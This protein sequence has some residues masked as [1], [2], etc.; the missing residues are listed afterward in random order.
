MTQPL[1]KLLLVGGSASV[2][3]GAA[4]TISPASRDF[5]KVAVRGLREAEFQVTLSPGAA[6]GI[7][8][9][10]QI[11]GPDAAEFDVRTGATLDPF[12]QFDPCPV[13]AQGVVC[14]VKVA[15]TPRSL[16]PKTATLVVADGSSS[17]SAMLKGVGIAA[18]CTHTVVP[19]NYALHY[20]GF[21][22]WSDGGT[23]HVNVDVVEGVAS[24]NAANADPIISGP[25]LVAVEFGESAEPPSPW[26][27]ITVACPTR[28][29]P[30]P[31]DPAELGHGE[32]GSYK[33]ALGISHQKWLT[34][35]AEEGPPRLNGTSEDGEVSYDLCPNGQFRPAVRVNYSRRQGRCP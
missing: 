22:N 28:Y 2:F 4:L 19:C 29:P 21:V 30:E 11:I 20:S 15:F 1:I 31:A 13:G 18:V 27:R 17:N 9:T 25:G 10:S 5:G 33:R 24:C 6:R 7:T 12:N 32:F 34:L 16:G 8:L 3:A 14:T 23:G 26:Y 35:L